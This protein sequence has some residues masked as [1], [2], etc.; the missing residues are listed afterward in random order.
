LALG[1]TTADELL[2]ESPAHESEPN[3]APERSP[4]R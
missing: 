1:Q 3:E 2:V 4:L